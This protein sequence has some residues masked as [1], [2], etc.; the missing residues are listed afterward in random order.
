M[1]QAELLRHGRH[2][3]TGTQKGIGRETRTGALGRNRFGDLNGG[4]GCGRT[5][6]RIAAAVPRLTKGG[7]SR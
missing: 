5:R 1:Q 3:R 6:P 7:Y 2:A 4:V